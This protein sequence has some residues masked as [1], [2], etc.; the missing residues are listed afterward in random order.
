[1]KSTI[2]KLI[3]TATFALASFGTLLFVA[4]PGHAQVRRGY[5]RRYTK[6]QVEQVLRR[7]EE[8]SDRFV[9]LFDRALDNSRLDDSRRE[10]RLNERARELEE[11]TDALRQN[12]D[13]ADRYQDSRSQV[14]A[15]LQ[16]ANNINTVVL[17]R[18]LDGDTEQQW[19]L[20]RAELNALAR[21]YNLRGLRG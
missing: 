3:F 19:S 6:A 13:R 15:V 12:F 2:S 21:V 4:E 10:D 5:N 1:M 11:R 14:A 9:G 17:R 20:L 7:I 18:R 16:T 8:R